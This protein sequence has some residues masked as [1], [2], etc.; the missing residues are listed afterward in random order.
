M[1]TT[2]NIKVS[3]LSGLGMFLKSNILKKIPQDFEVAKYWGL[4]LG[5]NGNHLLNIVKPEIFGHT[6]LKSIDIALR[7]FLQPYHGIE[8]LNF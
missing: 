5:A 2:F 7:K 3:F 8:F 4:L 1:H 6:L